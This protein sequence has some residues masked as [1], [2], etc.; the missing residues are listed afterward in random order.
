MSEV[1]VQRWQHGHNTLYQKGVLQRMTKIHGT[2]QTIHQDS[3]LWAWHR[4]FLNWYEEELLIVDPQMILPYY[5]WVY[6]AETPELS[7]VWEDNILGGSRVQWDGQTYQA[8]CVPSGPFKAI[9][10]NEG[11]CLQRQFDKQGHTGFP[12]DLLHKIGKGP[13][14]PNSLKIQ[15]YGVNSYKQW[16]NTADP[17]HFVS[18]LSTPHF[19]IHLFVG[20]SQRWF[21][22]SCFDG[23]FWLHHG[24]M[25]FILDDWMKLHPGQIQN[26]PESNWKLD[27]FQI[28]TGEV[29][30]KD[31]CVRYIRPSKKGSGE[32]P[33]RSPIETP[34]VD[35]PE[36]TKP[37]SRVIPQ[38]PMQPIIDMGMN[39]AKV[40]KSYEDNKKIIVITDIKQKYSTGTTTHQKP[41]PGIDSIIDGVVAALNIKLSANDVALIKSVAKD[42]T[43]F[44]NINNMIQEF[45]GALRTGRDS[46]YPD[47]GM[48]T[49]NSTS[50]DSM[51]MSTASSDGFPKSS[52]C[53]ISIG[54]ASVILAVLSVI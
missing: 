38:I 16:L 2:Y 47:E 35:S 52:S 49:S 50:N 23:L 7:S 1:E 42:M 8:Q 27:H 9:R 45:V 43:N 4:E 40:R 24:F 46:T 51:D 54:V 21:K 15:L 18:L 10:D 5:P 37:V 20:G 25:D 36:Y 31:Y 12:Q 14:H 53:G 44:G 41:I 33:T 26:W 29:L 32:A 3:H 39:P 13:T 11:Q 34:D 28:T 6:D 19:L 17:N 22:S 48:E 30:R